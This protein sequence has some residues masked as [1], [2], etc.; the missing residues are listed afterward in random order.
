MIVLGIPEMADVVG[1]QL[2]AGAHSRYVMDE[3]LAMFSFKAVSYN[4]KR[5]REYGSN[6]S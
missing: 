1:G 6:M 4:G 3:Q 2:F 5:S